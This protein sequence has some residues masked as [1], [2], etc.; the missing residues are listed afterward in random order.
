MEKE[1]LKKLVNRLW[2]EYATVWLVTAGLPFLYEMGILEEGSLAHDGQ[3]C[4]VVQTLIVLLTLSLIPASLK[5]YS[6]A[7]HK[8]PANNSITEVITRYRHWNEVRLA[9]LAV[10][11]LTGMSVYYVT[12]SSI[13]GLCALLGLTST[14]F[15]LP[16]EKRVTN[17]LHQLQNEDE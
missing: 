14:L 4:Y 3:M 5:I 13:G 16:T 11:A 8:I 7:I 1:N 2:M 15:C 10:V 12:L 17:E 6:V 9:L